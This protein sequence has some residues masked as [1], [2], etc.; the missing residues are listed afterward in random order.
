MANDRQINR[1]PGLL[2]V[3]MIWQQISLANRLTHTSPPGPT[4]GGSDELEPNTADLRVDLH[5][6]GDLTFMRTSM[7]LKIGK[8]GLTGR[9]GLRLWLQLRN[10]SQ[11]C[12]LFFKKKNSSACGTVYYLNQDNPVPNCPNS[13]AP[14]NAGRPSIQWAGGIGQFISFD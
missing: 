12:C 9:S 10:S 1:L 14:P 5:L 13:Y 7:F 4:R 11:G 6:W 8:I 3:K 2:A